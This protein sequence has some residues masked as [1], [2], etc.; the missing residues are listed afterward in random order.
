MKSVLIL[1]LIS[2]TLISCSISRGN[3]QDQS[4]GS[5]KQSGD[6]NAPHKDNKHCHRDVGD[7]CFK[8]NFCQFYQVTQA[9]N[10]YGCSK[11]KPGYE[12]LEDANGAGICQAN[13]ANTIANCVWSAFNAAGNNV[14][15]QCANNFYLN[16]VSGLCV[17]L[18]TGFVQ[19]AGCKSYFTAAAAPTPAQIVC[20]SCSSNQTLNLTTNTCTNGCILDNC[21]SCYNSGI[22]GTAVRCFECKKNKIGV[23]DTTISDNFPKCLDCEEW[24]I[25]LLTPAAQALVENVQNVQNKKY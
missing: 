15:Y 1:T 20:Q 21:E 4:V 25:D 22:A 8:F 14:C 3:Y 11:C 5:G 24:Q 19:V 10:D 23:F 7:V 13:T 18:P 17:A 9:L 2:L 6:V 12:L 16:T